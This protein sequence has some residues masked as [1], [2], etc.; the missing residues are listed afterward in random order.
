M[1]HFEQLSVS[2]AATTIEIKKAY[3]KLANKY[4]PDRNDS[5]EAKEKFQAIQEAYDVISDPKKRSLYL[6]TNYT[7]ITDPREITD[8]FWQ[9]ALR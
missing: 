6:K 1:D 9:N 3:K 8:S 7:V 4:H 5:S 2:R